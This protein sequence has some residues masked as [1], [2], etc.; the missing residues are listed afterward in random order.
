MVNI[1]PLEVNLAPERRVSEG[2]GD[3]VKNWYQDHVPS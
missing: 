1:N 3:T 2:Q